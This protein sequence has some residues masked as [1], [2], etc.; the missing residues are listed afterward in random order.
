MTATMLLLPDGFQSLEQFTAGWS[1]AGS[2][3]RKRR[4]IASTEEERIAFYNCAS[5]ELARAMSYLDQFP[6]E[7][8]DERQQNLLNLFLS[9]AHV[10][11][12]VEKQGANE[13]QHAVSHAHF[14]I[15]RGTEDFAVQLVVGG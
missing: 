12:A 3:A 2:D 5:G 4:R 1:I 8:F 7:H 10:A 13:A 9:L 14:T 15:T 11:L 6:I